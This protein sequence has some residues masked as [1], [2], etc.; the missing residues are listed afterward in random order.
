MDCVREVALVRCV[1]I[2]Y[3][4]FGWRLCLGSSLNLG[5]LDIRDLRERCENSVDRK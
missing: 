4:V 1:L 2:N 3:L 5:N